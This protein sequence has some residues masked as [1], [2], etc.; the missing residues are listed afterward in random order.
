MSMNPYRYND[1][2]KE[3]ELYLKKETSK[4]ALY[5]VKFQSAL[6]TC[7]PENSLVQGEYYMSK[8]NNKS[9]LAVIVHGMGDYS[10]IPCKFLARSLL[11]QGIA[12]FLPYLSLHSK[13][14]PV[15]IR[16]NLPNLT[17]GQWFQVYQ[18]SVVDICQIVDWAHTREE[19]E[20]DRVFIGGISY[21]GFVSAI[22][23]GID[24]RIKAGIFIV[25]GGNKSLEA[26]AGGPYE[27]MTEEEIQFNGT[28]VGG[29]EPYICHWYSY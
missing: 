27:A 5:S 23:M 6:N 12:C 1:N 21:G 17:P 29:V 13:R 26:D 7:Y 16:A 10:T 8:I 3:V 9:P 28:A 22:A 2:T 4:L 20:T 11:R 18:V 15:V 14:I 24:R 25:T 19:L